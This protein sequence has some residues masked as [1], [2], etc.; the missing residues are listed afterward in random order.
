MSESFQIYKRFFYDK[1]GLDLHVRYP[2]YSSI[3]LQ[4]I[5]RLDIAA[6]FLT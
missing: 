5:L 1:K 4:T 2:L 3:V 6:N